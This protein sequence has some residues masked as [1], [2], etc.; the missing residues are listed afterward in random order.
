MMYEIGREGWIWR[1]AGSI[2]FQKETVSGGINAN[3]TVLGAMF[4]FQVDDQI[5]GEYYF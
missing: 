4:T 3:S 5:R 1:K 2:E